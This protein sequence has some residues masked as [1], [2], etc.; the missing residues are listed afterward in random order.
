MKTAPR[1]PSA[2][3]GS[4]YI[5]PATLYTSGTRVVRIV[6]GYLRNF[7]CQSGQLFFFCHSR[8]PQ[9]SRPLLL[10]VR[11]G[12]AIVE[13]LAR[14]RQIITAAAWHRALIG[15]NAGHGKC[16]QFPYVS[17]QFTG[18]VYGEAAGVVGMGSGYR[19]QPLSEARPSSVPV[20]DAQPK[21]AACRTARAIS[22]RDR[23]G[24]Q[25]A[26]C[27]YRQQRLV[28]THGVRRG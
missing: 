12:R 9:H 4:V 5:P 19:S 2:S 6:A 14:Q 28:T 16:C 24:S 22:F 27:H 7:P 20:S 18:D 15:K 10:W 25:L 17:W 1:P 26:T 13:S 8:R 3:S 21:P 11:V 23:S